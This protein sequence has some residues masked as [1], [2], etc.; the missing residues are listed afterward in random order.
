MNQDKEKFESL[1]IEGK[2]EALKI[3]LD[4]IL[5]TIKARMGI[6]PIISTIFAALL[7]IATFNEQLIQLNNFVR[8]IISILLFLIPLTLYF[9]NVDLKM[10]LRNSEEIIENYIGEKF[11][12]MISRSRFEKFMGYFPDI[13]IYLSTLVVVIVIIL[14]WV[15]T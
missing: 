4:I 13:V 6:L 9:Y 5:N 14:I 7:V 3:Q 12:E 11:N 10:G 15:N 1:P 2:R 8:V